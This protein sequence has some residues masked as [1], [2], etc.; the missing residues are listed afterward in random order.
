M[1]FSNLETIIGICLGAGMLCIGVI[2]GGGL[3]FLLNRR[4]RKLRDAAESWNSTTGHVIDSRVVPRV[5]FQQGITEAEAQV[6]VQKFKEE[7]KLKP[8]DLLAA[9]SSGLVIFGPIGELA[10]DLITPERIRTEGEYNMEE[11][12]M[13]VYEYEVNGIKYLSNRVRVQDVSGPT[14][15]GALYA[16]PLL[17]RYPKGATVTVY[18]NPQDHKESALER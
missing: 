11:F 12:P 8:E 5:Y 16:N 17:K 14:I 10:D 18:Y 3:I 4:N 15:G 6:R 13:V 2:F 7:S 1:D 9:L